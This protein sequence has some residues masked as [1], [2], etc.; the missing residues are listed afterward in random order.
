LTESLGESQLFVDLADMYE[1][2][3][4]YIASIDIINSSEADDDKLKDVFYEIDCQFSEHL[5][6][7]LNSLMKL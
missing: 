1:I 6:Y 2:C 3:R 5:P 4:A 7:H